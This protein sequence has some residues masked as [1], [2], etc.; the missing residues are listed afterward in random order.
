MTTERM[1]GEL[2]LARQLFRKD[3][4]VHFRIF[5]SVFPLPKILREYDAIYRLLIR[6]DNEHEGKYNVYINGWY[7]RPFANWKL[8]HDYIIKIVYHKSRQ[9]GFE[10]CHVPN[11]WGIKKE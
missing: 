6:P 8:A 11:H 5:A 7:I 4:A 1:T 9:F 10:M 2:N 3:G